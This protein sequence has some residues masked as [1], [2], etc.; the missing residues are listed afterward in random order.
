VKV[1]IS[2]APLEAEEEAEDGD[3]DEAGEILGV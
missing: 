2:E 1:V 3:E